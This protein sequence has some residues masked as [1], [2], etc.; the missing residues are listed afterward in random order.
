MAEDEDEDVID[1][2]FE[3]SFKPINPI[4]AFLEPCKAIIQRTTPV[5]TTGEDGLSVLAGGADARWW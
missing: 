1:V 3:I 5:L 2:E 4:T